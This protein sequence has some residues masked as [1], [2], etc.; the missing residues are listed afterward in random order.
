MK[1]VFFLF[2]LLFVL[3]ILFIKK[4][5]KIITLNVGYYLL[6]GYIKEGNP[7]M[8]IICRKILDKLAIYN[9]D[10]ICTQE[11]LIVDYPIFKNIYAE[12]GYQVI[13]YCDSHPKLVNDKYIREKYGPTKLGNVIYGKKGIYPYYNIPDLDVGYNG[14]IIKPRCATGVIMDNLKIYNTHLC[15]GRYDDKYVAEKKVKN[16]AKENQMRNILSM[17]PDIIVGDLNAGYSDDYR[18]AETLVKN[19]DKENYKKWRESVI[20]LLF[21]NG[22]KSVLKN[23]KNNET[24]IRGKFVVDWI[25]YKNVNIL[26]TKIIKLYNDNEMLADHHALLAE[27]Y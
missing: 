2:L 27:I 26:N 10:I 16:D 13:N 8:E 15:G 1:I 9:P 14:C 6:G 19:L 18:F 20:E 5:R 24:T 22:Y 17:K 25:F 12:Y 11:D 3:P 4:T 23:Y 21:E 7:D